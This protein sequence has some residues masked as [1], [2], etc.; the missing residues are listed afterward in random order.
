MWRFWRPCCYWVYMTF[1]HTW[2]IF[3]YEDLSTVDQHALL[4]HSLKESISR[5]FLGLIP[6]FI[7]HTGNHLSSRHPTSNKEKT[8]RR[9][10]QG[11]ATVEIK[12]K[13]CAIH[14]AWSLHSWCR[15]YYLSYAAVSQM[16]LSSWGVPQEGFELIGFLHL[17]TL[18]RKGKHWELAMI[19]PHTHTHA[20]KRIPEMVL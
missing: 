10:N 13:L 15:E 20:S 3:I 2:N 17:K 1:D 11:P 18:P 8:N 7:S 4:M 14:L 12:T 5:V 9:K 16:E 6:L 19:E